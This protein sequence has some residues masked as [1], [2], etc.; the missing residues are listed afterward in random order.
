M[1]E[2]PVLFEKKGAAAWVTLN[3]AERMNT[4]TSELIAA[5]FAPAGTFQFCKAHVGISRQKLM[6]GDAA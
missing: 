5:L 2:A 4:L 3:R 1:M 6:L